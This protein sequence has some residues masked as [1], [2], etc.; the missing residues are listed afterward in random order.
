MTCADGRPLQGRGNRSA[1]NRKPT[2][3]PT[4]TAL[5]AGP[6]DS[7]GASELIVT[8]SETG[9]SPARHGWQLN[10]YSVPYLSFVPYHWN[11]VPYHACR[12]TTLSA[13]GRGRDR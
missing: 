7:T 11:R 1:P 5:S 10:K 12:G 2:C 8:F 3:G 9:I 13:T 4:Q 6:P